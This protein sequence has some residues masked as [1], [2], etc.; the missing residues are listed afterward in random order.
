MSADG[1]MGSTPFAASSFELRRDRIGAAPPP[2]TPGIPAYVAVVYSGEQWTLVASFGQGASYLISGEPNA[3]PSR[4]WGPA[5]ASAT[6][7]AP[8]AP[9]LAEQ[10]A[11]LR[12]QLGL[13]VSDIAEWMSVTRP[14]VYS[15]LKDVQPQPETALKLAEVAR[16]T[17]GVAAL[18]LDRPDF[19][20]K[21]PL[22]DGQSA[23]DV[24]RAGKPL[25]NEQMAML[26]ALDTRESEQRRASAS[27]ATVRSLRDVLDDS[28]PL[29]QS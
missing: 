6:A 4:Y 5:P 21:R 23:L 8:I 2:L 16:V 26:T 1:Y 22:F 7:K 25:S 18:N 10:V 15:W 3:L 14:T 11:V 27:G 20:L 13:T 9:T 12:T 17:R 24:M 19:V 29:T 28:T